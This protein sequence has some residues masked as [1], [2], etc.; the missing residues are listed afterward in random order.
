MK[1]FVM[2]PA[3]DKVFCFD[4]TFVGFNFGYRYKNSIYKFIT[5]IYVA[6]FMGKRVLWLF[7]KYFEYNVDQIWLQTV[8]SVVI[9]ASTLIK[10]DTQFQNQEQDFKS[11]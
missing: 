7:L 1:F 6:T 4:W 10:S 11:L 3:C 9:A 8:Q 2:F 5:P